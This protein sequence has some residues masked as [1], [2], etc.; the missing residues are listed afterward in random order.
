MTRVS[1]LARK[2]EPLKC[3]GNWFVQVAI[4]TPFD[5]GAHNG[6]EQY[7]WDE[8]EQRVK[9]KY[10][11][12]SGSFEAKPTVV[13]QKGRVAPGSED[14]TLWQVKPWLK[15]CYLPVWLS[16]VII[17]VDEAYSH[18][19]CSS[20]KTSGAGAWMYIMTREPVV[21]DAL[22]EPLKQA[23]AAAGWDL[24]KAERVPQQ[25]RS[26]PPP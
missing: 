9:V 10:T 13:Y 2:I 26:V 23:A 21:D 17:D 5:R 18:M 4:P 11:F 3:M 16:Y 7:S 24:S 8:E 15:L 19:V 6:L 1:P 12:S 14:G 22:L 25:Q 20:P